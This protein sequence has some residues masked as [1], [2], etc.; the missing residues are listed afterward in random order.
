MRMPGP[1]L[2]N[3]PVPLMG[4]RME[5]ML[6]VVCVLRVV[7]ADST[8]LLEKIARPVVASAPFVP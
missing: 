1:F 6:L 5:K 7:A 2:V 3:G 8:T 4:A